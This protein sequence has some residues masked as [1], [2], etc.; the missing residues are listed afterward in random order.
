MTQLV[1]ALDIGT[2]KVVALVAELNETGG[3]SVI[4]FGETPASGMR[5]GMVIDIDA[6]TAAVATAVKEAAAMANCKLSQVFVSLG[7]A[8][9]R[10]QNSAGMVAIKEL[11]VTEFDVER[12]I[13]TARTVAIPNDQ[14]LLHTLPQ[15]F[16][17]DG[18]EG[19]LKPLGM[20]G[21]RLEVKAHLITGAQSAIDNVEKCVRRAGL[22]VE[23]VV[24]Q[25]LA[26]AR[27]CLTPEEIDIGVG[28]L[29]IGAGTTDVALYV[30]GAIRH[31][32]VV[33]IAGD[34]ITN[35]IAM[36]LRTSS[37]E[38]T[39]IKH[40]HGCA[41]TKLVPT[42]EWI[43]VAGVGDRPPKTMAR[44]LLAEVVEPRVEELLQIVHEQIRAS[45]LEPYL[46]SGYVLTGGT[47]HL[48]GLAELAEEVLHAPVRIGR[49]VYSGA[50][51]ELLRAPQYAAAI[52]LLR[53]ASEFY[54]RRRA[55]ERRERAGWRLVG[56]LRD[57]FGL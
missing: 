42:D 25:P 14:Y 7:G 50:L 30:S 1:A 36:A 34:Q 3:L 31:T 12:A 11:E 13:D 41:L 27:A 23:E 5:K 8:H 2:S 57:V 35:D 46:R 17:I 18:Q 19:V 9:L 40:R 37:R 43:E 54:G 33:P 53:H 56:K 4:G 48:A 28:L 44:H 21:R 39:D 52:G 32:A 51:Q 45:G 55:L 6:T 16:I 10:S 26:S 29:D 38:A 24:A 20:S 49:P 22:T 15:E 47:A